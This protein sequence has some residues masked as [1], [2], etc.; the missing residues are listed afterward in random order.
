MILLGS[1]ERAQLQVL[2]SNQLSRSR[3]LEYLHQRSQNEKK[4]S[5]TH[6]SE[7]S[8]HKVSQEVRFQVSAG[9]KDKDHSQ[10]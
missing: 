9:S 3:R 8:I 10:V 7:E 4:H 1:I 6:S 5:G 2:L